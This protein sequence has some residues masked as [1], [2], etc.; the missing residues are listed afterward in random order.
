MNI[1]IEC[2]EYA[3]EMQRGKPADRN[4]DIEDSST[5]KLHFGKRGHSLRVRVKVY[6]LL[7]LHKESVVTQI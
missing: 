5:I 7:L 6:S 3:D 2:T 4:K 1:S